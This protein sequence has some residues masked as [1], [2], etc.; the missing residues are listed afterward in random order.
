MR[1]S[2]AWGE[3]HLLIN[4]TLY[5]FNKLIIIPKLDSRY[6]ISFFFASHFWLWTDA[7]VWGLWE[8][9]I[10]RKREKEKETDLKNNTIH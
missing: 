2:F 5:A 9:Q 1:I 7:G 4:H 8:G 3:L 6:D 10:G